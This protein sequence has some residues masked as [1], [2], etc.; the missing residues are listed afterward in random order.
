MRNIYKQ[1]IGAAISVVALLL[2]VLTHTVYAADADSTD[3]LAARVAMVRT[4]LF[5]S[6]AARRI[7]NSED[8]PAKLKRQQAISI[9]EEAIIPGDIDSR[10]A[11]LNDA[12]AL[13]YASAALVSDN[14]G[15]DQ[16]YRQD[17]DRRQRSLDALLVAHERIME[18]KGT[19]DK[20]TL[21]L[22]DIDVDTRAVET[23]LA[24]N[25]I[26]QAREHLDRAYEKTRLSVEQSREGET[27]LRELK[28]ETPKDEFQYELDRNDTHRMLLTVLLQEKM[29]NERVKDRV[30]SFVEE[31]DKLRESATDQAS[32]ERFEEAIKLL[33]H[34]TAEL[35]KAIRG[36][37]VYIPG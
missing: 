35:V 17:L 34:S 7:E 30:H 33:E 26:D 32:D 28:F 2:L 14:S 18:E 37:G 27:L 21:L 6:S 29:K 16:K 8:E 11:K 5:E 31:A 12:V 25:K 19:A 1:M 20:H 10:K 23:L 24:E 4:L 22:A 15:S 9:F 13:L 36:A 3:E